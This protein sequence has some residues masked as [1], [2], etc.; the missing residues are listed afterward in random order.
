MDSVGKVSG[1]TSVAGQSSSPWVNRVYIVDDHRFFTFALTS[2]VNNEADL[3][4]CGS[5]HEEANV[6]DDI[7]RLGPDII[8]VDVRL[9]SRDGLSMAT[10]LRKFSKQVP[11]LFVSS[12]QNPQFEVDSRWLEPCSFVEKTKDPADII[13][14]IRQTLAK[15]RLLQRSLLNLHLST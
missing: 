11:L 5:G 3:S 9:S 4:V 6:L 7:S 10:A 2:L 13:L 15:F 14:G 1:N 8:V 12:L